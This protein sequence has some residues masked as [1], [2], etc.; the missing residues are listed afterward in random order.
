MN[1]HLRLTLVRLR[2][3]RSST[4]SSLCGHTLV[5]VFTQLRRQWMVCLCACSS[6]TLEIF[7]ILPSVIQKLKHREC[8][9]LL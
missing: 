9:Y 8:V 1:M 7:Q 2:S 3:S 4:A 6:V 5:T